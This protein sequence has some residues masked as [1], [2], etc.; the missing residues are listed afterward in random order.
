MLIE[1]TEVSEQKQI[2]SYLYQF[3]IE[4]SIL[5][6]VYVTASDAKAQQFKLNYLST[7]F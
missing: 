6:T 4:F 5:S 3:E 1:R 2:K 7:F